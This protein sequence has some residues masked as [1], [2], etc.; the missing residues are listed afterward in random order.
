MKKILILFFLACGMNAMAQPTTTDV[1]INEFHYDGVTTFKQSDQNEFVE[2]IVKTTLFNNKPEFNK[3]KLVLYSSGALD[4]T[5]LLDGRGLPYN[6]GSR[7]YTLAETEH[8]LSGFQVC[9]S[10]SSEYTILSKA[11]TN[12]Q[13]LPAGFA[14]IYNDASVVQLLSYEKVFKIAPATAGGGAAAGLTTTVILTANGDTAMENAQTPNTHSISLI[15]AGVAYNNFRWTDAPTQMATPCDVNAGQTLAS[16]S[17]L[18]VR[19]LDFTASGN[20]D[21]IYVQWLV[22][23]DNKTARYELELR[24]ANAASYAKQAT[25]ARQAS[26]NGRYSQVMN[27]LPA[28]TYLVR[29]KAIETNGDFS[30]SNERMVRLGK[31]ISSL[32]LY[33]N[34]VRNSNVLLQFVAGESAVYSAQ[35]IDATGRVVKQQSFGMLRNGQLNTFTLDLSG[36]NN[37]TYSVKLKGNTEEINTRIIVA[38]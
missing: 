34:P 27:N 31:G 37:G 22:N 13:D 30:Y 36:V 10:G 16:A 7:L 32:T 24:E 29:I 5:G 21:K 8:S 14:I 33:P 25:V 38:R 35:V 26:A 18:P 28:G 23:D 20:N 12:L 15:G 4:Q 6:Q 3:L 2:I 1:W 9:P 11:L 17:P 19:W